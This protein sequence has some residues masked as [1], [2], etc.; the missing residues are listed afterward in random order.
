MEIRQ[1]MLSLSRYVSGAK[2]QI[3][4]GLSAVSCKAVSLADLHYT[5]L[6]FY[7]YYKHRCFI[8][9]YHDQILSEGA[10]LLGTQKGM[11]SKALEMGV[12][13]HRGLTFGEHGG[14]LFFLGPLR[15]GKNFLLN[16]IFM[17]YSRDI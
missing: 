7:D 6:Y 15:E 17:R 14:T 2:C 12:C 13:F 9:V 4:Q 16:G 3:T 5:K 1:T 8:T 11:L 10:P